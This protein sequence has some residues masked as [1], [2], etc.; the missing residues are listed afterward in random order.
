[1]RLVE[2]M[3]GVHE[4][5]QSKEELHNHYDVLFHFLKYSSLVSILS[6]LFSPHLV[7]IDNRLIQSNIAFCFSFVISVPTCV[8]CCSWSHRR[9]TCVRSGFVGWS[10]SSSLWFVVTFVTQ[11]GSFVQWYERCSWLLSLQGTQPH[12]QGLLTLYQLYRPDLVTLQPI[13]ANTVRCHLIVF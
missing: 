5:I 9:R 11:S 1:M 4:L 10:P 13:T 3:V 7:C 12:I 6:F 2:W 8:T